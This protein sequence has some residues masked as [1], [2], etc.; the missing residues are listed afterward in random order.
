[1]EKSPLRFDFSSFE[2]LS[3]DCYGTLIDWET[4]IANA[5]G[6]L[7]AEHGILIE[8][9]MLLGHFG[10]LE[11]AVEAESYRPYREVL[12]EVLRRLALELGFAPAD[13]EVDTFAESP[14]SWP[15]FPDSGEA[16]RRLQ[17]H[18]RL[19]IIS[20]IED[21]LFAIN[22]Q[23]LGLMF[24]KVITAQQVG[25]YKPDQAVFEFALKKIDLPKEKILH[26]AQSL[27]HDIVPAK[28]LGFHTIWVNRR[29]GRPGSGATPPISGDV[30]PNFEVRSL[31]ELAAL[32]LKDDDDR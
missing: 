13:Q 9:E 14:I 27:Y 25:A 31:E 5:L 10:R 19:A 24:D 2:V 11:A 21:D 26:V 3:F 4:G 17:G 18:Y 32:L 8:R 30:A 23:A 16:L 6:P 12:G 28:K 1:V 20:N 7:L 22:E 15:S 29:F